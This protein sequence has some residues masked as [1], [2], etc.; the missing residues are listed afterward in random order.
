MLQLEHG[1]GGSGGNDTNRA[2]NT[3][4]VDDEVEL[5]GQALPV[6]PWTLRIRSI[7][8]YI[9]LIL[10]SRSNSLPSHITDSGTGDHE[11]ART[12]SVRLTAE[13]LSHLVGANETRRPRTYTNDSTRVQL[14]SP[15]QRRIRTSQSEPI[16]GR[17]RSHAQHAQQSQ[18]LNE[19]SLDRDRV[20]PRE[21][22]DN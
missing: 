15:R 7:F 3:T 17:A 11:E 22:R 9:D 8:E 20:R 19:S 1:E 13:S 12:H 21:V 10:P 6:N 4:S 16:F 18:L 2:P 5:D 14:G